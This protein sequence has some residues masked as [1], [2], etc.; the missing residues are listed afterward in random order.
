MKNLVLLF[1][2]IVLFSCTEISYKEPQPKGIKALSKI[3]SAL[4]GTYHWKGDEQDTIIIF[5][6]GFKSIDKK[7]DALYVSD[8]LVLK[9]YKGNY[10]INYR[11]DSRW[12]LRILKPQKNGDLLFMQMKN[13]PQAGAER[14]EF[15]QK[16]SMETP[17]VESTVDSTT[18]FIIDPSPKKLHKLI[19]S[20]FFEEH[21][22]L[23]KI[24]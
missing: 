2:G 20:G 9:K 22:Q 12:L 7:E 5:D 21:V 23:T 14:Q 15:I 17:V 24:R 11:D 3:P 16:L 13:V 19:E 1:L 6:G 8:S 4:H 10:Y 18:Y